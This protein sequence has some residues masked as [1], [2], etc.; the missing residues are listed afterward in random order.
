MLLLGKCFQISIW[1]FGNC[2]LGEIYILVN[3]MDCMSQIDV[4]YLFVI[5]ITMNEVICW[6]TNSIGLVRWVIR[7]IKWNIPHISVVTCRLSV[8]FVSSSKEAAALS[9]ETMAVV[10]SCQA[11]WM[12]IQLDCEIFLGSEIEIKRYWGR[13]AA[14][15]V[16]II[17]VFTRIENIELGSRTQN[18]FNLYYLDFWSFQHLCH[19]FGFF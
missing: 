8:V 19:M 16:T 10:P 11:A 3:C 7:W 6:V 4:L 14:A 15:S 12:P 2:K 5:H 17:A 1:E 13:E 18:S 9:K